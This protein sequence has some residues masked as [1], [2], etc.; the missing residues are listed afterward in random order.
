MQYPIK[1]LGISLMAIC[2]LVAGCKKQDVYREIDYNRISAIVKDNYNLSVFAAAL[3]RTGMDET[4]QEEEG[5]FTA[6]APSDD[7]FARA[8]MNNVAAL[9]ARSAAWIG[10][11]MDYHIVPGRYELHKFPYLINQEVRTRN[12]GK[13]YVSRWIKDNNT[14]LTI[15]GARVILQDIPAS[16]GHL[17]II[18]R[19]LEPYA[20]AVL[21]DA[22]TADTLTMFAEALRRSGLMETLRKEGP[23]TVF[24]PTNTA[25]QKAGYATI[26]QVKDTDPAVLRALCEFHICN[27]L[28]FVNDYLLSI[29]ATN[30]G[31]QRM[32]NSFTAAVTL[33]PNAQAPGEYKGI[34]LRAP[35][36][37]A[38]V[39]VIRQDILAGNGVL[40]MVNDVLR[41]TR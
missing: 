7:A 15:N 38:D 35:G 27:D 32:I 28:R 12:G 26:Q 41:L 16:N 4:L 37:T 25:M 3:D 19:V 5:P 33:V 22:V 40:H 34:T 2:W 23:Y 24:A 20:H 11:M 18:D 39:S 1:Q 6:L 13:L 14:I 9:K 36:N 30:T 10:R 8:G 29:G 21:A 17:Q 31:S